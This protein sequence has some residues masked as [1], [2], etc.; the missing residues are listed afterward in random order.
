[1]KT[2]N[3]TRLLFRTRKYQATLL[4]IFLVLFTMMSCK[5][6]TVHDG[7]AKSSKYV[8]LNNAMHK[9][10]ADHMQ[11]TYA[12]VDAY[13]N[14][15]DALQSNLNRLLQNQK[16]IGA[17]IAPFYGSAAGNQL[18]ALLTTHINQAVPVLQSA[19][20]GDQAALGKA[21]EDWNKNAQDIADFLSA[22]NPKQWPKNEMREMMSGHISQ[23]TTYAVDLLKK[24]YQKAVAN[25]EL[26]NHHMM[27]MADMLSIGIANQ[28]P[29]KF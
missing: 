10:W 25:Y 18:S 26:T 14:N 29:E 8:E 2:T 16:D 11:W 19:K 24:D 15:T 27:M 20:S 12:T 1:M 13:F 17:A 3:T 4:A 21:L 28:F 9:L 7:H 5:K 23:T 22:A 6:E